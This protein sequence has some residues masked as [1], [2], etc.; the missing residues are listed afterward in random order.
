MNW[1]RIILFAITFCWPLGLFAQT[2]I[3]VSPKGND[4]NKGTQIRPFASIE[5]AMTAV[6]KTSGPVVIYLLQGT[7]YLKKPVV[8]TS[9]DSRKESEPLTITNFK[10]QEVIIN[11]GVALNLKWEKY[12]N[13]IW[14]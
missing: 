14:K 5:K 4:G 6:R 13:G 8:F 12:K 2:N 7:Y 3:Y 1:I 11:G 10:N 9:E